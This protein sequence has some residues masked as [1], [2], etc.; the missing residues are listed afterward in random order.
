MEKRNT[1]RRASSRFKQRIPIT[2]E[3]PEAGI[4]HQAHLIDYSQKGLYFESDHYLEPG[5]EI[6]VGLSQ[7]PFTPEPCAFECYG[8]IVKWRK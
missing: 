3:H 4:L 2:L 8:S 6:Y 5:S 1:E 7:S